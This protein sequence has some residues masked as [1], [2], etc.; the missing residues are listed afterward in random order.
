MPTKL[1][2]PEVCL[3]AVQNSSCALR[4]VPEELKTP[5]FLLAAESKLY[6]SL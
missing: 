1:K 6:A 3:S 2:T 5:E 4:F